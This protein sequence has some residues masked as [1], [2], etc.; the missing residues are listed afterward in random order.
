MALDKYQ[1][2]VKNTLL[3]RMSIRFSKLWQ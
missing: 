3:Q 2:Q 1:A